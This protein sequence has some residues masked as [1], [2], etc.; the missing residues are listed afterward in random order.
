[1]SFERLEDFGDMEITCDMCGSNDIYD[2]AFK[3]ALQEAKDD[4]WIIRKI[5]GDW[6]HFCDI[7]CHKEYIDEIT[8]R[9]PERR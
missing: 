7:E 5:D 4:G 2:P 1:M 6:R 9:S 8:N 3:V